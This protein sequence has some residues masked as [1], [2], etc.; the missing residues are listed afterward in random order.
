MPAPVYF[1]QLA[2]AW[3]EEGLF[4]RDLHGQL[5]RM[6]AKTEADYSRIVTV[7]I[8]GRPV[9]IPRAVPTTDSQ[10][11]IVHVDASG[12]TVPRATTI[13][14]A[15][16]R[17]SEI[18]RAELQRR[19]PQA[20][21]PPSSI[22][23]LCHLDHLPP[24]GVCRVCSV[25]VETWESDPAQPD[26]RR[27]R[28]QDKLVPACV[29]PVEDQMIVHTL[30][31]PDAAQRTKVER[32]V[33]VLCELLAAD[34][35]V[36]QPTQP[37]T[38]ASEAS[39]LDRLLTRLGPTLGIEPGRFAGRTGPPTPPDLSSPLI[40]VQHDACILCDRCTRSCSDVKHNDIL[41][42]QGKGSTTQIAFDLGVPMGESECVSCGECMLACPTT[43][44]TF[45]Q[46]VESDWYRE[47]L[48]RPGRS[49][50]SPAEMEEHELLRTL[51]WRY[52]QWNQS[53]IVRWNVQPGEE[54]CQLGDYG[55]TAF[56]L[57]RGRF[58]AWLPRRQADGRLD[59]AWDRGA[60]TFAC[61][62][63]ELILGEMTILSQYP[64]TATVRALTAG[65]VY[66]IRRNVLYTLQRH[67]GAREQLNRV[68]RERAIN[69][70]LNQVPLF[71]QLAS[72]DRQRCQ[73]ILGREF[74]AASA[75][76]FSSWDEAVAEECPPP[77]DSLENSARRSRPQV[78]RSAVELL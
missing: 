57:A 73:E 10:G 34:Q 53:S 6:V 54:L 45:R 52:R 25:A 42:R 23:T 66:E 1:D 70:H 5:I 75:S 24:A 62:P 65:E 46:P 43:A 44:L 38:L 18:Q 71:A 51:P 78:S 3:E 56:L 28:R 55:T 61:G 74:L 59:P 35:K 29:Q 60:P 63:E 64:R 16:R 4:A 27:K 39:D 36:V 19:D 69:N 76:S 58:G 32:S 37:G 8:D 30:E 40:V 17:L 50:V 9:R 13:L 11:N 77:R 67:P 41:A 15:A 2:Q 22:P 47:Q 26:V 7:I 14:D 49:A 21:A 31:S 33:R 48:K 12:R 20:A 68:Y 72:A